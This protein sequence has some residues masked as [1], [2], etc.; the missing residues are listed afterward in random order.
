MTDDTTTTTYPVRDPA[1]GPAVILDLPRLWE[2]VENEARRRSMIHHTSG[3]VQLKQI[4]DATGL[5]RTTLGRIRTAAE[6]GRVV[7]G[8]RGGINVNAALTLMSFARNGRNADFGREL[9]GGI[10]PYTLP[11][12]PWADVMPE[13]GEPHLAA[14]AE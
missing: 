12:D 8:Q 1:P 10:T 13:P 4:A 5:D 2:A 7:T 11:A 14:P 3:A 9:R 6:A